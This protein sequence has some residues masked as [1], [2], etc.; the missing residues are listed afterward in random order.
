MTNIPLTPDEQAFVDAFDVTVDSAR[1]L[2]ERERSYFMPLVPG[3]CI[4]ENGV[5][6][7]GEPLRWACPEQQ[8]AWEQVRA[9]WASDAYGEPTEPLTLDSLRAAMER[10]QGRN[11]SRVIHE[12]TARITGIRD[13][14]KV[15][16][17]R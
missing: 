15:K 3:A 11:A 17:D 4:V 5:E 7:R 1:A 13:I 6:Q 12:A 16:A 2:Y 10:V 9:K 14:G 8:A